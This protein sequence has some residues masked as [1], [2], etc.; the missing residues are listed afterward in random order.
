MRRSARRARW[1]GSLAA[2]ALLATQLHPTQ[3]QGLPELPCLIEPHAV[4]E[5]SSPVDGVLES[6]VVERGDQV[7]AGQPVARLESR[8]EELIVELARARVAM[9]AEIKARRASL[10]FARRRRDRTNSLYEK[11]SIPFQQKDEADTEVALAELELLRVTEEQQLAEIE[12]RRAQANLSLR[13]ITSPINGV[14]VERMLGPGESVENRPVLK[15]AQVDPLNVEVIVPVSQLGEIEH[16]TR[17]EVR[18]EAPAGGVYEAQVTVLDQVV[19]AA[20]G[21]FGVRLELPNPDQR[22]SAGLRC[23]VRFLSTEF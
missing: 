14:V 6:V 9:D 8:V 5:V 12:L 20:S 16:G 13:T 2:S 15:I 19:D 23:T 4:T 17:A 22:I 7:E 1:P 18:P 11:R 21:T 3:G 10:E